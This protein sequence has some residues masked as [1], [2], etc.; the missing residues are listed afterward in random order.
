MPPSVL[1]LTSVKGEGEVG[2]V[3]GGVLWFSELPPKVVSA[4]SLE[5]FM[6]KVG[7]CLLGMPKRA[8]LGGG[9]EGPEVPFIPC[10]LGFKEPPWSPQLR[11]ASPSFQLC[12][13]PTIMRLA[14]DHGR[15]R[16]SACVAVRLV[17]QISPV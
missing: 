1:H 15:P 13:N 17:T 8:F 14:V 12:V 4:L 16:H 11:A 2:L 7:G 3:P 5:G 9:V 6:Q 10:K